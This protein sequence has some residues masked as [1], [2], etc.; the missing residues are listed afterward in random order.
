MSTSRNFKVNTYLSLSKNYSILTSNCKDVDDL[1]L[2]ILDLFDSLEI[3]L[4]TLSSA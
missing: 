1:F 3:S 4:K 2:E